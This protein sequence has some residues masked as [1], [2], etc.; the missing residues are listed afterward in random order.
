MQHS[1]CETCRGRT[2]PSTSSLHSTFELNNC[3]QSPK[4]PLNVFQ[5]RIV[6]FK[7]G[8]HFRFTNQPWILSGSGLQWGIKDSGG[9]HAERSRF[10]WT[11]LNIQGFKSVCMCAF[12]WLLKNNKVCFDSV[13]LTFSFISTFFPLPCFL[14]LLSKSNKTSPKRVILISPRTLS[15]R[16]FPTTDPFFGDRCT[17]LRFPGSI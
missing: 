8:S 10:L 16:W 17:I 9:A 14:N 7:A 12:P 2:E 11:R 6:T 1:H 15:P 13:V 4:A 5:T 3:P